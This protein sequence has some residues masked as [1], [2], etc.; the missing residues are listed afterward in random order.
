[1]NRNNA[2]YLVIGIVICAAAVFG[3]QV[4][5]DQTQPEGMQINAGPDGITI[6]TK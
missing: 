6:Q 2:L 1:M 3:Y 4:Y 5:Q